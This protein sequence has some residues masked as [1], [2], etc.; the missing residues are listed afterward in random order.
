MPPASA[1]PLPPPPA[2]APTV[3]LQP[4]TEVRPFDTTELGVP[5]PTGVAY[6]AAT[7]TF[8]VAAASDSGTKVATTSPY[9][10]PLGATAYPP[11]DPA[12]L[13]TDPV[14]GTVGVLSGQDL[15]SVPGGQRSAARSVPNRSGA[16]FRGCPAGRR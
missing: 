3:A 4:V 14:S 16:K 1:A 11:S 5:H 2:P 15:L 8:A 7:N 10:D 12:T 6:D 9:E 13:A